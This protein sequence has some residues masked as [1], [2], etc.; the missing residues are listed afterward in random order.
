MIKYMLLVILVV[1]LY[2]RF[3]PRVEFGENFWYLYYK[4]GKPGSKVTKSYKISN[5]F[6]I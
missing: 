3:E 6:K 2:K 5:P 1:Y 4:V